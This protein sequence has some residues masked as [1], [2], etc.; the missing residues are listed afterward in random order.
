MLPQPPDERMR[1]RPRLGGAVSFGRRATSP[2]KASPI[3]G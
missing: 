3:S 1:G 2:F